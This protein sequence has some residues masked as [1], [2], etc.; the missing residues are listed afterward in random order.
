MRPAAA[1]GALR[2]V[3]AEI[4]ADSSAVEV[5]AFRR[6]AWQRRVPAILADVQFAYHNSVSRGFP[7]KCCQRNSVPH[8]SDKMWPNWVASRNGIPLR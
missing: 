8:E 1:S 5:T 4:S 6:I 3:M 7:M 2:G